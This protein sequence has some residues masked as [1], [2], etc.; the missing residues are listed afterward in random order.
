MA[1]RDTPKSK[2]LQNLHAWNTLCV[3]MG[4]DGTIRLER[5]TGKNGEGTG[6]MKEVEL[7]NAVS[8]LFRNKW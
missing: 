4:R 1:K 3:N 8:P 5:A 2:A 7:R 6:E